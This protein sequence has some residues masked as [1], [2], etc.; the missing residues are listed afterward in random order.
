MA[1]D[2]PSSCSSPKNCPLPTMPASKSC[3]RGTYL[4]LSDFSC[5]AC[6]KFECRQL[7]LAP[8]QADIGGTSG[9]KGDGG[10]SGGD[11][12]G[13]GLAAGIGGGVGGAVLLGLVGF[14]VYKRYSEAHGKRRRKEAAA[15][16]SASFVTSGGGGGG[17]GGVEKSGQSRAFDNDGQPLVLAAVV[18]G[19]RSAESSGVTDSSGS[20]SQSFSGPPMVVSATAINTGGGGGG[21]MWVDTPPNTVTRSTLGNRSTEMMGMSSNNHGSKMAGEDIKLHNFS[22]TPFTGPSMA[23]QMY[24]QGSNLQQPAYFLQATPMGLAFVPNEAAVAVV[25]AAASAAAAVSTPQGTQPSAAQSHFIPAVPPHVTDHDNFSQASIIPMSTHTSTALLNNTAGATSAGTTG[26]HPTTTA[27][28]Q[29]PAPVMPFIPGHIDV[30]LPSIPHADVTHPV[31]TYGNVHRGTGDQPLPQQHT[32]TSIA[33]SINSPGY[34]SDTSFM[35]NVLQPQQQQQQQQQPYPRRPERA[36]QQYQQQQLQQLQL[37]QGQLQ[38]PTPPYT[39]DNVNSSTSLG[40]SMEY[41]AT[42]LLGAT[43]QTM[44]TSMGSQFAPSV[45][46]GRFDPSVMGSPLS[47]R[48]QLQQHHLE[49]NASDY[50]ESAQWSTI[51]LFQN[52]GSPKPESD[53]S[54]K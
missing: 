16:M 46:T 44:I 1:G 32:L 36:Y 6:P 4:A 13:P 10:R 45:N 11:S 49:S 30:S 7:F 51:K 50:N 34:L 3:S 38:G 35:F 22:P 54:S 17:G 19:D 41:H 40:I 18:N 27:A 2:D 23:A 31:G 20:M 29:P 53:D 48:L 26:T 52:E 25:A 47:Q 39:H 42:P 9:N 15:A 21:S 14:F 24:G 43:N 5:T 33:T 37:Q 12:R 8:E 28:S